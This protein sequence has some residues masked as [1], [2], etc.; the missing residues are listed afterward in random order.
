MSTRWRVALLMAAGIGIGGLLGNPT[1]PA[2]A[3]A[4]V[5]SITLY[6]TATF[7]GDKAVLSVLRCAGQVAVPPQLDQVGSYDNSP[8]AGCQAALV[9][10]AGSHVMC[11]GRAVVPP[12]FRNAT[13]V[14]MQ[15]GR[16]LP[17]RLVAE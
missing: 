4:P 17:C 12:R 8:P 16:S 6:E 13:F 5:G 1:G 9:G 10:P 2:A 15:P 7:G 11:A 14:R 3:Q